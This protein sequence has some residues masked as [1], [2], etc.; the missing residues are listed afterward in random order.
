MSGS[1]EVRSLNIGGALDTKE[2][3]EGERHSSFDRAVNYLLR[4]PKGPRILT[5]LK[6]GTPLLPDSIVV[7]GEF[8]SRIKVQE[9]YDIIKNGCQVRVGRLEAVLD[10]EAARCLRIEKKR[11]ETGYA[12]G[13]KQQE[14]KRKLEEW[15]KQREGS[16]KSDLFRLPARYRQAMTEL[17]ESFCSGGT[18]ETLYW[19]QK[20]AGAGRGLTPACDDAVIGMLAVM[21][22]F[23]WEFGE[24]REKICRDIVG[25]L[26]ALLD[27]KELTT[28][29][30]RKYLQCACQGRFARPL[31]VL[32]EWLIEDG[33]E[34]PEKALGQ[35]LQTGH[36]SGRD[37]L[38]GVLTAMERISE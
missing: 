36:T 2:R 20:V 14:K 3:L 31:C 29:V 27:R 34:I 24:E 4:T 26:E 5:F 13:T 23:S 32:A 21:N 15:L 33:K 6:E 11:K 7:S 38:Y 17:S 28:Q 8:F 1:A 19:F 9:N 18:E 10:G 12:S 16:V 30:S 22:A 25:E 37:M 35:I